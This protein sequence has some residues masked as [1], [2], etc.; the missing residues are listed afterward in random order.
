MC[1]NIFSSLTLGGDKLGYVKG[2]DKEQKQFIHDRDDEKCQ[3][4]NCRKR[5]TQV[6]HI[7]GKSYAY[8]V[9][10]WT[11]RKI[12]DVK[13]GVLLCGKCHKKVENPLD[14]RDNIKYFEKLIRE[15]I[16]FARD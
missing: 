5:G 1:Y 15:K 13:N 12:N 8:K 7:V 16:Y 14:W 10:K 6:H 2:F 9:L 4:P 3:F 11:L